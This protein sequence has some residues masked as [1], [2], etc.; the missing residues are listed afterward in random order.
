LATCRNNR[1]K[2]KT[3]NKDKG[4]KN[5]AALNKK[6]KKIFCKPGSKHCLKNITIKTKMIIKSLNCNQTS[7]G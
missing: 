6:I 1:Q 4:K 2:L 7:H 5:S 3:V